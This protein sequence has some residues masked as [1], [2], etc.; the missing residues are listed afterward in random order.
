MTST[1]GSSPLTALS[2][3]GV[4]TAHRSV[5]NRIRKAIVA[6][7]LPGGTRLVQADLARILSVSITPVREALQRLDRDGMVEIHPKRGGLVADMSLESQLQV[8][9][10]RRSLEEL[11]VRLAAR[12]ALPPERDEMIRPW[13]AR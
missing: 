8:L 4:L 1:I 13:S 5:A 10:I 3:E 12:R 6:G 9:E 2:G 7:E 11:T